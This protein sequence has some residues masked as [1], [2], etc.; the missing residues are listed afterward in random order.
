MK[1]TVMRNRGKGGKQLNGKC[2]KHNEQQDE[3]LEEEEE[4]EKEEEEG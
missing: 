3:E 4:E 1:R 2:S